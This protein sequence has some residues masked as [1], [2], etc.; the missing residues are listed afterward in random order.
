MIYIEK[1]AYFSTLL[2]N[3]NTKTDGIPYKYAKKKNFCVIS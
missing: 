3:I 1:K 2:I